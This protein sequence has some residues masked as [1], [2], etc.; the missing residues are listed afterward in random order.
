MLRVQRGNAHSDDQHCPETVL[1]LWDART[2]MIMIHISTIGPQFVKNGA[3]S[4][5]TMLDLSDSKHASYC[6]VVG[7][8][9]RS[10]IMFTLYSREQDT[11]ASCKLRVLGRN[12]VSQCFHTDHNASGAGKLESKPETQ[13]QVPQGWGRQLLSDWAKVLTRHQGSSG[14]TPP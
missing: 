6:V 7:V 3:Q 8:R 14:D 13:S 2:P 1:I 5:L 12:T 9:R 4:L 10:P 11:V